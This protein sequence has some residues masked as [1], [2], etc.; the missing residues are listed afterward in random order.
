VLG[1]GLWG[2]GPPPPFRPLCSSV[3]FCFSLVV[4][5]L[6]DLFFFLFWSLVPFSCLAK[7]WLTLVFGVVLPHFWNIILKF[8]KK[9]KKIESDIFKLNI[10]KPCTLWWGLARKDT[11]FTPGPLSGPRVL[12]LL[13]LEPMLGRPSI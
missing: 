8:Q 10:L 4:F 9:R 6:F 11:S 2:G 1:L 7:R 5:F 12:L 13:L 3:I